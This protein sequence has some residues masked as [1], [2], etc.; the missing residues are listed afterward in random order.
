[1][2]RPPLVHEPTEACYRD[3]CAFHNVDEPIDPRGWPGHRTCPE[4]LHYFPSAWHLR[5]TLAWV[6]LRMAF[7]KPRH[8]RPGSPW[9]NVWDLRYALTALRPKRPI[10]SCPL[11]AHDF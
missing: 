3:H 11:C 4:C 2:K 6:M 5:L 10:Y 9:S 8:W 1:M 7:R